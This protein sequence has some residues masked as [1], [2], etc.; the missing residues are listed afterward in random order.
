[1]VGYEPARCSEERR[2]SLC[3][4][5]NPH[6]QGTPW[7]EPERSLQKLSNG[8]CLSH[9]ESVKKSMTGNALHYSTVSWCGIVSCSARLQVIFSHTYE[10]HSAEQLPE[11]FALHRLPRGKAG[12]RGLAQG[13]APEILT[14]LFW[15][16]LGLRPS[17]DLVSG[18][19]HDP[20]PF[21][22]PA[23]TSFAPLLDA[24]VP[25]LSSAGMGSLALSIWVGPIDWILEPVP[26]QLCQ[27]G[28]R[29]TKASP[30][31]EGCCLWTARGGAVDGP[32]VAG[33][34]QLSVTRCYQDPQR[35]WKIQLEVQQ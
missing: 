28:W 33:L 17:S 15:V 20:M 12:G 32:A 13:G 34:L 7:T 18:S 8:A 31:C 25:A 35:S 5:L 6:C 16:S 2:L 23:D 11:R 21:D 29:R 26:I 14:V 30:H 1:M 19:S 3:L 27:G 9:S 22:L 24:G 10:L 4:K